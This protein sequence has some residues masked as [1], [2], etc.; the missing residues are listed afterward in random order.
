MGYREPQAEVGI[1]PNLHQAG[2]RAG[3]S[4]DEAARRLARDGPNALPSGE[5]RGWRAILWQAAREPMFALLFS[6]G[7]LYLLLGEPS[8]GILMFA[9]V[10]ATLG[11]TLYEESKAER[12]LDALRD[13]S[14]PRALVIRDGRR[15]QVDSREVVVGDLCAIGE[16]D[17][18]PADGVLVAG[19]EVHAD[20]SLL[21]GESLPVPKAPRQE[22]A[23]GAS[24]TLFSGTLVVRG[25]GLMEVTAIG[26]ASAIGAIGQ[27]LAALAPERSPLQKQMASV[28]TRFGLGGA[29]L[30]AL[31]VAYH[32]ARG[33]ELLQALLAGLALALALLPEEFAVVLA[34]FPALGASRLARAN[35]LTRQ[36]AA[37]ET[38]GAT[39]VLCVDKTGTLTEN[40]MSVAALY[41]DGAQWQTDERSIHTLPDPLAAVLDAGVLASRADGFEPMDQALHRLG[42]AL[43]APAASGRADWSLAREYGMSADLRAVAHGWHA[44]A[45]QAAVVAAKGAP[46]A[47]VDLCHLSAAAAAPLLAEADAMAARGLRV[48]GVAQARNEAGQWPD[49]VHDFDFSPLG[50]VGFADPLRAGVAQAVAECR[51]AGM[52]VMMITGDYPATALNIGREAGLAAAEALT[53]TSLAAMDDGELER[54]LAHID[55]CARIAPAQKLR[56]VRAL[57]HRGEIVAMTGDGVNDAPA[58]QA[59]HVGI[60]M[61]RRGTDVA[62]EAA[63]LVLTDDHFASIVRAVRVGRHI[64]ANMRKAMVYIVAVHVPTAGLAL[65]PLMLGWPVVLGPV[66]IVFLE[67]VIDPACA[68]AFENEAEEPDL[69]RRP[70]RPRDAPLI[71]R[72]AL[73]LALGQ[74]LAVLAAV[75][76][77][78]AWALG[79]LPPAQA[80]AFAFAV[81]VS[82]NVGLIFGN[83]SQTLTLFEALRLP[84]RIAWLVAGA[85]LAALAAVLYLESLAG[86]FRFTQPSPQQALAALCLGLAAALP[87]DLLKL[88]RRRTQA[89]PAS[90]VRRQE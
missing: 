11:M 66:H 13:L 50:L 34:L 74:G 4:A 82:A 37:I 31:L 8:E 67:L 73:L 65:L 72:H 30:S 86:L 79:A 18:V 47:I 21:T 46:E 38:L 26:A 54:S 29:A 16:G 27:S 56:I 6:A 63:D 19:Q 75:I 57:Q 84:N 55:I 10:L 35:V 43:P 59:A 42:A 61:G 90:S 49:A 87:F 40:R 24:A 58:L 22:A 76:G 89:A 41:A 83:R 68:L 25:H 51:T 17:R 44:G 39:T 77:A 2:P 15:L 7:L 52:R 69:M 85:A 32:L 9:L 20:E 64:Y 81:L 14:T 33:G 5:H 36:L 45:S 12:A 3:L 78:Y 88:A 1:E 48:L 23:D 53:G 28:I 80:R 60:A 62:R 70:P 71:D